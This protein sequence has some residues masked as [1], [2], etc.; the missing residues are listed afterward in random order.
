MPRN[1]SKTNTYADKLFKLIPA[2][3]VSAYIAIKGILDSEPTATHAIY[4][5]TVVA[6]FILLPF[7]LRYVAGVKTSSQIVV[8]MFSFVVWV[9]S[10]GGDYVGSI[11]WYQPCYGSILLILWTLAIPI[12]IGRDRRVSAAKPSRLVRGQS[13]ASPD[14]RRRG[15]NPDDP[16]HF[17][18]D[19][20][21]H[22]GLPADGK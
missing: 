22:A 10:L 3:W 9:I 4:Y 5:L 20:V 18:C 15:A 12:L 14:R 17:L 21:R 19:R 6:L 16:P 1:I 7:Y 13:K 2:E 8:T 11:S